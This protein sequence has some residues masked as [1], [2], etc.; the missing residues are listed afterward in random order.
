MTDKGQLQRSMHLWWDRTAWGFGDLRRLLVE[1]GAWP[2]PRLALAD[3]QGGHW[4]LVGSRLHPLAGTGKAAGLLVPEADCLWGSLQLP[5]MPRAALGQAVQEA[6]WRVSP[7]PVQDV[8]TAWQ[9]T[10]QADGGWA[11]DWG[12]CRASAGQDAGV[13]PALPDNAPVYLQRSGRAHP[14]PGPGQQAMR[15]R[16]RWI[17]GLAS[18]ALLLILGAIATPA[19]MPL[20]LKREAVVRALQHV[21]NIEPQAAPLRKQLDELRARAAVADS[22]RKGLE[23]S[24]PLAAVIEGLSAQLPD[25]A[26]LDR[27]EISGSDIRIAGVA[28]NAAELITQLARLPSFADVRA[29]GPSVR[30]NSANKERFT[31]DLRWRTEG[32]K[33]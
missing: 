3:A 19:L 26:S 5:A 8:M 1:R 14:V 7:L 4:K 18:A 12:I 16:Q 9:A 28:N 6:M 13:P 21:S 10:P 11:V 25:D 22:L 17:D 32:G 23:T 20:V 31:I 15:R 27:I 33:S 29:S 30:D 24:L 2:A